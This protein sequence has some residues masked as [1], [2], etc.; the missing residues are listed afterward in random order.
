MGDGVG[1]QVGD[2]VPHDVA[3]RGLEYECSLAD[4]ELVVVWLGSM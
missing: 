1:V 3:L 4:G 2:H